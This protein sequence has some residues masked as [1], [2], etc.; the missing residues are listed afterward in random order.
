M[1][2]TIDA[3]SGTSLLDRAASP[4]LDMVALSDRFDRMM[5]QEPNATAHNETTNNQRETIATEFVGKGE[6]I[7]RQ[8]FQKIEAF[9][10]DIGHLDPGEVS[11]RHSELT[12]QIAVTQFHFNACTYVAQSGKTGM[13]TLM[14]NQ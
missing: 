12:M 14:K 3:I 4:S 2:F 9:R 10:A 6:A 5:A 11:A 7:M 1:S 8:T 13:Q